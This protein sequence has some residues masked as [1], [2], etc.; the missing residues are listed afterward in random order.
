MTKYTKIPTTVDAVQWAEPGYWIITD[1]DGNNI[2]CDPDTFAK[3]YVE[4]YGQTW[5]PIETAPK[6]GTEVFFL[7]KDGCAAVGFPYKNQ[8]VWVSNYGPVFEAT[9]WMLIPTLPEE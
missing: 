8:G 7:S 2:S 1:A 9:H 4:G 3:T 6:D 5:Q